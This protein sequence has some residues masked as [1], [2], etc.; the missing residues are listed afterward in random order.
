MTIPLTLL[1]LYAGVFAVALILFSYSAHAHPA[2]EH[3][4]KVSDAV[5]RAAL[6]QLRSPAKWVLALSVLLSAVGAIVARKHEVSVFWGILIPPV[7]ALASGAAAV[8]GA[9]RINR[10]LAQSVSIHNAN[11]SLM[12]CTRD[13][14]AAIL[15]TAAT[16]F[17]L[18]L[19]LHTFL[20][21]ELGPAATRGL[22]LLSCC[23]VGIEHLVIAR[24]ASVSALTA[25]QAGELDQLPRHRG[26]LALLVSDSFLFPLLVLALWM[27][28]SVLGY[29]TLLFVPTETA[30]EHAYFLY[31]HL[32]QLL[33][34]FALAFGAWVVRVGE[35]EID[36]H[37]WVRAGLVTLILLIAGSWSLAADLPI[38]TSR[39]VA[40]GLTL[41]F[42]ALGIFVWLTPNRV[43][44]G[45]R[46]ARTQGL[47]AGPLLLLTLCY[48]LVAVLPVSGA[49]DG[50]R[51]GLS[52]VFLA[53][54]LAALPMPILWVMSVSYHPIRRRIAA[55]A[56]LEHLSPSLRIHHGTRLL[57]LIPFLCLLVTFGAAGGQL[58]STAYV[59][60]LLFSG[61]SVGWGMLAG[62]L[63][64]T[65][66]E[67]SCLPFQDK[68]RELVRHSPEQEGTLDLEVASK[69]CE[70]SIASRTWLFIA[71]AIGPAIVSAAIRLSINRPSAEW[72]VWCI[73]LGLTLFGAGHAWFTT[74][75]PE[76][77]ERA[78]GVM[79]LVTCL[80]QVLL[81]SMVISST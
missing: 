15:L 38:D 51:S 30:L 46:F 24:A 61:L 19:G 16:T 49:H 2:L 23:T 6:T 73:A 56:F 28:I 5:E 25:H 47:L 37:G 11:R 9:Q 66:I 31:P 21:Q 71:I 78:F 18:I 65:V 69:I 68:V 7:I 14:L 42:V 60:S 45:H 44:P 75:A 54:A 1:A 58:E 22:V 64:S 55:L 17:G 74:H 10:G 70:Q 35:D 43:S 50:P 26:S 59:P 53:A 13:A 20:S 62:V 29:A 52:R 81:I 48:V 67:K 8:F 57:G 76:T 39:P 3:V 4:R 12:H 80:T 72:S 41:F 32:L 77:S 63:G 36:E 34:L 79:S 27:T 40:L 33:G